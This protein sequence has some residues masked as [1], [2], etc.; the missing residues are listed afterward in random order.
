M[1]ETLRPSELSRCAGT[2]LPRRRARRRSAKPRIG[3]GC[4]LRQDAIVAA[5]GASARGSRRRVDTVEAGLPG[6]GTRGFH[7]P[8]PA[9]APW[10]RAPRPD[11]Y[12][13]LPG[14]GAPLAQKLGL[15]KLN[16]QVLQRTIATLAPDQGR[17]QG[18]TGN[19]RAQQP[20]YHGLLL[21]AAHRREREADL[22]VASD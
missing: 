3:A 1:I 19:S 2:A 16:F 22:V 6:Y 12:R 7:L 20:G 10:G 21:H 18:H 13:Q 11:P 15:P 17:S 4:A 9:P 14:S 8:E 5:H